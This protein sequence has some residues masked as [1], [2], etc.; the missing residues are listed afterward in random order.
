MISAISNLLGK[1]ID[2]TLPDKTEANRLKA[3]VA[4]QLISMDLEELKAATQ[5]ITVEASG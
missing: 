2:K 1:V 5:V 4:S 3:Q